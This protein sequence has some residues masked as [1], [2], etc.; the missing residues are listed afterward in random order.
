MSLYSSKA[1]CQRSPPHAVTVLP[2][3][4]SLSIFLRKTDWARTHRFPVT[5]STLVCNAADHEH[6]FKLTVNFI[7]IINSNPLRTSFSVQ[8]SASKAE[9]TLGTSFVSPF[10]KE[11]K[12]ISFYSLMLVPCFLTLVFAAPEIEHL[13]CFLAILTVAITRSS[14]RQL[15]G[16]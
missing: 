5:S 6:L 3:N 16:L 4:S 2:S 8:S 12:P 10:C 14:A 13:S 9:G 1:I 15:H 7:F 11:C